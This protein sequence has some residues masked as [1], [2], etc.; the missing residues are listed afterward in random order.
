MRV[1]HVVWI[2]ME[3]HSYD[4][5]V[6]SRS[7]PYLNRLIRRC[8]LATHYT[9]IGHPSLPNYLAA[10]A[11]TTGGVNS[12]CD[13][14]SCP[15]HGP[16]LFGQLDAAGRPWAGYAESMP[17]NCE[18]ASSGEYAARHNP[19]VYFSGIRR[20]CRSRDVPFGSASS[21]AL[22]RALSSGSLPAFSFV[23]PNL[24]HDTHDCSVHTGDRWLS[25]W[26]PRILRSPAYRKGS[27]VLF[28]TWDEG[29]GSERIPLVVAS[30]WTPAGRRVARA[31]SHYALLKTTEQLLGL[32]LLGHAADRGTASLRSAFRL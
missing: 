24:C 14:T 10:V 18:L 23:T 4:S 3:N 15:Q 25:Q 29:E 11:G 30:P 5:V 27:L 22:A 13:P 1:A 16:S 8:G 31:A 6:G 2:W 7:A 21:G 17:A 12:D 19:A 28:I 20:S 32:P 26:V 9:D